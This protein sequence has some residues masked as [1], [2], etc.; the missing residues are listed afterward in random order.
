VLTYVILL[1]VIAKCVSAWLKNY[2]AGGRHHSRS[3]FVCMY[4]FVCKIPVLLIVGLT[5][6]HGVL[7]V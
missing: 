4:V 7:S 1:S 5:N 3:L 2:L 6:N